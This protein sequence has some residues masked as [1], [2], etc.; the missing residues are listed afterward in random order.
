MEPDFLFAG[1]IMTY[2]R[3]EMLKS[4]IDK[5]FSQTMPPSKL[6]IVDNS[7]NDKTRKLIV[8]LNHPLVDYF[9][10]GFNSGPAGAAKIGLE[11]LAKEGYQWIYW[12]DDDD[13]PGFN[14][15]FQKL[16]SKASG[17]IGMMGVVGH[18]FSK[19]TGAMIRMPDN[20]LQSA[21]EAG[22]NWILVDSIAGNQSMIVNAQVVREGVLPDER[23][24]FGFEE[25]EF[26]LRVKDKNFEIVVDPEIFLQSRQKFNRVNMKSSLYVVSDIKKLH[27][28]YYSTRNLL[29]ILKSRKLSL[30]YSYQF[31]KGLVK[32]IY[33]F[34]FGMQYGRINLGMMT[35]ALVDG[36][37]GKTGQVL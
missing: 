22:M 13:P 9:P 14:D 28:Q 35:Q 24:F 25:L 2:N 29:W 31:F 17:R 36:W 21:L 27:R 7:D 5:I 32:A 4:T 15:I 30:A 19:S 11:K 6:L 20:Q 34:R 26:C 8:E 1:F 37:K 3:S 18:N 12:G 33:G 23:L 16:I 10:V